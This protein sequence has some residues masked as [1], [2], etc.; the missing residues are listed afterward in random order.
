MTFGALQD[1]F[2]GLKG[3]E[4][5]SQPRVNHS[6]L[7]LDSRGAAGSYAPVCTLGPRTVPR[8]SQRRCS[9]GRCLHQCL[10]S[11]MPP[12]KPQQCCLLYTRPAGTVPVSELRPQPWPAQSMDW[13]FS[14]VAW[15][16]PVLP[17]SLSMSATLRPYL[18]Q[19]RHVGVGV[20]AGI[21]AGSYPPEQSPGVTRPP[22]PASCLA[23][24]LHCRPLGN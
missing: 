14:P 2:W 7:G 22:P 12:L 19:P 16:W 15:D 24:V 21:Q 4:V 23:P 5:S 6:G 18:G 3:L 1:E 17:G 13:P 11:A 10:L 9:L 20:V 8:R